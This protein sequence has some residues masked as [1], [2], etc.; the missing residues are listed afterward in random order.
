MILNDVELRRLISAMAIETG[1]AQRP[2]RPEE[3][4]QP[5]SIDLR[6]DGCFWEPRKPRS[7]HRIDFRRPAIGNLEEKIFYRRR[8]LKNGEGIRLDPGRLLLGRTFEEFMI[9]N[10]YAGKLE[11]RSTFARL[12]LS[13]H[14]TGDFINPGWR[15]RMPLQLVNHGRFPLILTPF[16]PVAQLLVMHVCEPSAQPYGAPQLGSKYMNDEGDPSRYW[17]D[18][19]IKKLQQAC[20]QVNVPDQVRK[21][22][23]SK[24]GI[25]DADLV[26]RFTAFMNT[27]QSHEIT[28]AD[29]ILRSFSERDRNRY[30]NQL[31]T[32]TFFKW[33][34]FVLFSASLGSLFRQPFTYGHYALWGATAVLLAPG[35]WYMYWA[36]PP[37]TPFS[38]SEDTA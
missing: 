37:A 5:C 32:H 18:S 4:I 38:P 25:G 34:P 2:F 26:E 23:A 6:L 9:P 22:L 33:F 28:S 8:T 13:V 10:G 35:S 15:G 24:V 1:D 36:D 17:L 30:K 20:S 7:H 21:D 3:Q 19:R 31:R 12:G 16:L 14:C 11:G 29:E 27:L